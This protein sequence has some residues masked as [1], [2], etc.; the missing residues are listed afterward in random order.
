MYFPFTYFPFTRAFVFGL[1]V[2]A[3]S[4][5]ITAEELTVAEQHRL[6]QLERVDEY[7]LG[8][9]HQ[10]TTVTGLAM[11]PDGKPAVGFKIGGWGRSIPHSNCGGDPHPVI[12]DENGRFTLSLFNNHLYW[13]TITD[14]NGVYV[15][16]DQHFE[17][18]ESIEPD[19]IRFRLQKGIPVEGVVIDRDKN[20]PIAGLPVWLKHQPVFISV[21]E[22]GIEKWPEL[23]KIAQFH[24]ETR[25]DSQGKF[26]FTAL[27]LEYMISLSEFYGFFRPVPQEDLDL[28]TRFTDPRTEQVSV[29]FE[30]PTPWR[31]QILQK[32][33]T[34]APFYPVS[35]EEVNNA[36][37]CVTD[38][39]GY[40]IIYKSLKI[41]RL[42]VDTLEQGQW[43]FKK[44]EDEIL[45]HNS[46]F[47]L[48]TPVSAKGQLIRKSTG[49]PLA[50]FKF[51][52]R[53]R[54]YYTDF[55]STDENGNFESTNLFLD[56]ET[57]LCYLNEPDDLDTCAFFET[58]YSF[59]PTEPNTV[60]DLGVIELEESGWLDPNSL[61][62]LPGREIAIEGVT[63][64]GQVLDWAKYKGKV[65]LLDFWATWCGPCLAEIPRL[66]TLYEKYHGKGFEIVGISMDE[67]LDA[68]KNGLE[69][70][71]FPW[72]NLADAKRKEANQQTMGNRFA[73]SSIPRCILVGRDG[74]VISVEARGEGLAQK[75]AELFPA[76]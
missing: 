43:F 38:K 39:D 76:E 67:D 34:P 57:N 44:F 10:R 24:H 36:C 31:G 12:T 20:E 75:L 42:T 5:P 33:G 30:I 32:D 58:F 13:L 55:V 41:R 21:R 62:N 46:V 48:N 29:T 19:A 60:V 3:W 18:K 15:A 70:H 61:Q 72:I 26:R 28:Y 52:S 35:V 23:E 1:C 11:L 9:G 74:K 27:P 40:F 16:F 47:Q 66:K 53:P 73:V 50:N 63:L 25:T 6:R 51:A 7:V 54:P 45:P 68:L 14:P 71:Q 22:F 64:D 37:R 8:K 56:T 17:L 2:L 49:K 59:T 69:R 4:V 65:V